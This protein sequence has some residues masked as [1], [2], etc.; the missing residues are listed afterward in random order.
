[1]ISTKLGS[2]KVAEEEGVRHLYPVHLPEGPLDGDGAK[3]MN[4]GVAI[5]VETTG[6][7]FENDRLIELALRR[8]RFTDDGLITHVG[9][10][11]SWLE[12]P[13]RPLP[14]K[15]KLLTGLTDTDLAGR[16]VD[17]DAATALIRSSS[18]VIAHNARFDRRWVEGRLPDAAGLPWA[19]SQT[20][21]DW[22][23]QGFD[24]AKLGHLLT[25]IGYYHTGHRA[26]AD[27]DALIRLLRHRATDERTLL[28]QLLETS[29]KPSWIVRAVGAAFAVKD[30][31][32]ARHY[33]WDPK[34]KVWWREISDQDRELEEWWLLANIYNPAN[35][36]Q[37]LGPHF[38][39]ISAMS[40]FL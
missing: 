23:G 7:D 6:F 2:E 31:L 1:M 9:K 15:I 10:P 14:D 27:V 30:V 21:I 29:A 40:R 34:A 25:Q 37:A 3:G 22:L 28:G 8:F 26:G 33:R 11:H 16:R 12:D 18:L 39:S 36:P 19:C 38:V 4:I 5:D 24:G 20:E 17:T 32:K 13:R 35:R